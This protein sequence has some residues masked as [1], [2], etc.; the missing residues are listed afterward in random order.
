MINF[1]NYLESINKNVISIIWKYYDP[2]C[3]ISTQ[4][5]KNDEFKNITYY[6]INRSKFIIHKFDAK[7]ILYLGSR[8]YKILDIMVKYGYTIKKLPLYKL[9]KKYNVNNLRRLKQLCNNF[10]NDHDNYNN[11]HNIPSYHFILHKILTN[12]K[13]DI[14]KIDFLNEVKKFEINYDKT[15]F[16]KVIQIICNNEWI[17]IFYKLI[18]IGYEITNPDNTK[19]DN[20]FT[21]I[22]K[23]K[24]I[25]KKI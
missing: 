11:I 24:N 25:D 15:K 7:K 17:D 5:A 1:E 3:K 12:C 4:E 6:K 10:Y 21:I 13:G 2:Y 18:K 14:D 22:C 19:I 23:T 8:D 16:V 9:I 20:C